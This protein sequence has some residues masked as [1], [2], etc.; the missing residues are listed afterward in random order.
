MGHAHDGPARLEGPRPYFQRFGQ[1]FL[2]GIRGSEGEGSLEPG[3][4]T[5]AFNRVEPLRSR[6]LARGE[7]PGREVCRK[8]S[9]AI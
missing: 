9:A 1:G 5:I 6:D 7:E 8:E 4:P 2:A 3:E